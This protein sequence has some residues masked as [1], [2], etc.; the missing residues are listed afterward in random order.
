MTG[1][2]FDESFWIAVGQRSE[3]ARH[4]ARANLT[5][6]LGGLAR[7]LPLDQQ[8]DDSLGGL[9]V[10]PEFRDRQFN[11]RVRAASSSVRVL[12]T[13]LPDIGE[14]A[15]SLEVALLKCCE[16][17]VMLL[18]PYCESARLRS[19]AL[20]LPSDPDDAASVAGRVRASIDG[21]AD[22][23]SRCGYTDLLKV[24]LYS[25]APSMAI[26]QA[27]NYTLAGVCGRLVA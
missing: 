13:F 14:L 6:A 11:E 27:D 7:E 19:E 4:L 25:G 5:R 10:H 20:G 17:E 9:W 18:D 3:R 22:L 21:M 2:T 1:P 16:V 26:Y 24:R 15:T 8:Q 12:N 23:A